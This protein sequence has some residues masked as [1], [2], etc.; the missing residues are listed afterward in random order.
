LS[1]YDAAEKLEKLYGAK[2]YSLQYGYL[3]SNRWGLFYYSAPA[4]F[5]T[6]SSLKTP[7]T[8]NSS[9]QRAG[10]K[11]SNLATDVADPTNHLHN[12]SILIYHPDL[13]TFLS[14]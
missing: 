4:T 7:V 9:T 3:P 11:H 10:M 1:K 2:K 5:N 13:N 12:Q 8:D 14:Q 6:C